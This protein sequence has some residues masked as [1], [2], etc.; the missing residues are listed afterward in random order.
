MEITFREIREFGEAI[1]ILD[2][3]PSQISM[4][5]LGNTYCTICF[6]LKHK[7]DVNAIAQA[8]M[9]KDDEKDILGS[10]QIGQ[11][12]VR[13]QGR[14]VRPFLI[15][16][17]E[18]SINKGSYTDIKVINHMTKLGLLSVR[19]QPRTHPSIS[20]VIP[21]P[22]KSLEIDFLADIADFPESGVAERYKRLGLSVR[23]GQ[24]LKDKL[25]AEKLI[26]EQTQITHRGKFH[27]IRLTEKGGLELS[28]LS[29]TRSRAA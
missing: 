3:H 5:A 18:F 16:V 24:K 12:V 2:Q 8:M 25:V 17:P 1:I 27:V 15:N 19:K 21:M 11:A 9:L 10:L 20:F 4:P 28:E 22:A 26:Q 7:T 29:E 13:L 6:N 14:V 23:Q